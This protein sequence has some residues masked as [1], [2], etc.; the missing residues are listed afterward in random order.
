MN[1]PKPKFEKGDKVV[2]IPFRELPDSV[3]VVE[4]M[5]W[6]EKEDIY[7]MLGIEFEPRWVYTF[8]DSKRIAVEELLVLSK[9]NLEWD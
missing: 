3:L 6:K 8:K 4:N 5:Y 7:D 9:R 2:Y 1:R